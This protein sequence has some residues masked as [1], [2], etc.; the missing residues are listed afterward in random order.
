[1]HASSCT[2]TQLL[3]YDPIN[4]VIDGATNNNTTKFMR[5]NTNASGGRLGIR[6]R[7]QLPFVDFMAR[8]RNTLSK[9]H[10]DNYTY[11]FCCKSSSCSKFQLIVLDEFLLR[12]TSAQQTLLLLRTLSYL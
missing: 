3:L 11:W 1:M 4:V 10:Y 2:Y 6:R 5:R 7:R 12:F 8:K 9:L